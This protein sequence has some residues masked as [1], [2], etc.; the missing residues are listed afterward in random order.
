MTSV[1][2]GEMGAQIKSESHVGVNHEVAAIFGQGFPEVILGRKRGQHRWV[3]H[4]S[5]ALRTQQRLV[6]AIVQLFRIVVPTAF[7][8]KPRIGG[9]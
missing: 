1:R 2:I 9:K 8:F 6:V 3:G 4:Q 5:K 7:A